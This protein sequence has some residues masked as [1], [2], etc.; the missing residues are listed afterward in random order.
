LPL[1]PVLR[2]KV[3]ETVADPEPVALQITDHEPAAAV[4]PA[5]NGL[6]TPKAIGVAVTWQLKV[7]AACAGGQ[8]PSSRA[9]TVLG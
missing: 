1:S 2:L 6:Y 9:A 4:P 3:P 7:T 8:R 5:F